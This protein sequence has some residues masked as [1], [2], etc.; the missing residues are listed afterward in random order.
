MKTGR[1]VQL[2]SDISHISETTSSSSEKSMK[3]VTEYSTEENG[4]SDD[5]ESDSSPIYHTLPFKVIGAA[6]TTKT[7]DCLDEALTKMK[8]GATVSAMLKL[9][10]EN[11]FDRNAIA[12]HLDYGN[13]LMN[14]QLPTKFNPLLKPP[15][16]SLVHE[17]VCW[18][19]LAGVFLAFSCL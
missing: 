18:Q 8:G 2:Q 1:K 13:L 12:V 19:S 4:S 10:P 3:S 17:G 15:W 16:C 6:H 7:Q 11:E 9:E 14:A 5:V